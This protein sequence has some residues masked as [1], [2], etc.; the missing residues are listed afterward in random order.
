MV[1]RQYNIII[2]CQKDESITQEKVS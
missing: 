2:K 1:K